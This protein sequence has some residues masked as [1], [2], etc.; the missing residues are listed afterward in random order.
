MGSPLR[1]GAVHHASA[2]GALQASGSSQ[3][4]ASPQ[5]R[6]ASPT[7]ATSVSES[8]QDVDGS[9]SRNLSHGQQVADSLALARS[10]QCLAGAAAA[11]ITPVRTASVSSADT[12]EPGAGEALRRS[13]S[14]GVPSGHGSLSPSLSRRASMLSRFALWRGC[15]TGADDVEVLDGNYACDYDIEHSAP[16]SPARSAACAAGSLTGATGQASSVC[17][18][19]ADWWAAP[20]GKD[21]RTAASGSHAHALPVAESLAPWRQRIA[22][23]GNDDASRSDDN[24]DKKPIFKKASSFFKKLS[25]STKKLSSSISKKLSPTFKKLSSKFKKLLSRLKK[26]AVVKKL[27]SFFKKLPSFF[28]KDKRDPG[29]RRDTWHYKLRRAAK[30]AWKWM[31]ID[32][33][34]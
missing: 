1:R 13:L 12:L 6:P 23:D 33:V 10:A 29:I 24:E 27:S 17:N 9:S 28:K 22:P 30:S 14:P 11:G 4:P 21:S 19:S 31:P 34:C 15:S 16:A 2:G 32:K 18:A 8:V 7:G 20:A 25:S 3:G 26:L 5:H